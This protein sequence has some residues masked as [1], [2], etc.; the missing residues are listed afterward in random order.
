MLS[1]VIIREAQWVETFES[2]FLK[3]VTAEEKFW[4]VFQLLTMLAAA[5]RTIWSSPITHPQN[6]KQDHQGGT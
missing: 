4:D 6:N 3:A 1:S 5:Q 2:C